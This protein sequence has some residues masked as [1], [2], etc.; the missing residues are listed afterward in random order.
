[1]IRLLIVY[2]FATVLAST[3]VAGETPYPDMLSMSVKCDLGLRPSV[4]SGIAITLE[5]VSEEE[6]DKFRT[7]L[8]SMLKF[9]RGSAYPYC[10]TQAET[11]FS[12]VDKWPCWD[13]HKK[14]FV[15]DK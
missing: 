10:G 6:Y 9:D 5:Y 2:L 15:K 4:R 14:V 1:M 7:Y 3:V 11:L 8:D 13:V 12:H